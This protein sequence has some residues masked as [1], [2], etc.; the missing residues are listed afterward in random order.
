MNLTPE[1][2]QTCVCALTGTIPN[3]ILSV[4]AELDDAKPGRLI[5]FEEVELIFDKRGSLAM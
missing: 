4:V 1:M 5:G 3:Q 2:A